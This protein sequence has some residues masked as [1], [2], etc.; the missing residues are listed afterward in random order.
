MFKLF[1]IISLGV[2]IVNGQIYS[3]DEDLID[4]SGGGSGGGP[5]NKDQDFQGSG[6]IETY[7]TYSDYSTEV[8]TTQQTT[9]IETFEVFDVDTIK[10]NKPSIKPSDLDSKPEITII[11]TSGKS[12]ITDEYETEAQK[13][14]GILTCLTNTDCEYWGAKY[15]LAALLG[16]AIVGFLI[17]GIVII[18]ICHTVKKRDQGTYVV[19]DKYTAG[20]QPPPSYQYGS[21][22]NMEFYA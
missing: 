19:K 15:F 20:Q 7:E 18:F 5:V 10:P 1:K 12:G 22:S 16:G 4:S 9:T 3:D 21:K 11:K 2:I 6:D 17:I 14:T 8:F 13:P